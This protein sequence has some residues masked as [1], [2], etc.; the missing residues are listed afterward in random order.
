MLNQFRKK[1]TFINFY[2]F[3]RKYKSTDG[4]YIISKIIPIIK[5]LMNSSNLE[6]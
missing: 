5:T 1:S 4:I 2:L 3:I 6:T